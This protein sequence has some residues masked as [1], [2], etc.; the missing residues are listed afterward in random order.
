MEPDD[1]VNFRVAAKLLGGTPSSIVH[2]FAVKVSREE[3]MRDPVEWTR[4]YPEIAR[5]VAE[6]SAKRKKP[7]ESNSMKDFEN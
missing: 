1:Y 6:H 3:R 5:E 2:Q 4:I 7:P